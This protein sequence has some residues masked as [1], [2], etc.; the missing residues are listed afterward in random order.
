MGLPGLTELA[1][2]SF[3]RTD[4][5][6]SGRSFSISNLFQNW[7]EVFGGILCYHLTHIYLQAN[8]TLNYGNVNDGAHYSCWKV[9]S[10]TKF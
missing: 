7:F 2:K 4:I 6:S 3:T 9:K 5:Y 1:L 10:T 8:V